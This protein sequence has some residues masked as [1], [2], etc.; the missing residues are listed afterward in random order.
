MRKEHYVIRAL[1]SGFAHQDHPVPV[2]ISEDRTFERA[3]SDRY[4]G[5]VSVHFLVFAGRHQRGHEIQLHSL[6]LP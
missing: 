1:W 4:I 3:I 2:P 5:S 6:S